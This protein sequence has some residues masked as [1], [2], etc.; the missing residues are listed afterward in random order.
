MLGVPFVPVIDGVSLPE[1]PETAAA[2]GS[3]TQVPVMIGCT[4]GEYVT[5]ATAQPEMDFVTVVQLLH[6]RVRP[7]GLSGEE[8]VRRYRQALPDHTPRGIWRA[9]AGDLVFQNPT[10]RFSRAHAEY[11]P[12]YKYL[13]GA[14]EPDEMG[15]PHGAEVGEVW[16]RDGMDLN[17]LPMRQAIADRNFAKVVHNVWVSFILDN[18][19]RTPVG[20]WPVY[21]T[22]QP[23]VLRLDRG[24]IGIELDPFDGRTA[25]WQ[26]SSFHAVGGQS[27]G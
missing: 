1:H 26:D 11:Q 17:H 25:L 16:Y 18:E 20:A 15:A 24:R 19:P 9:V 12:V 22:S 14:I 6:E 27:H 13:Y 3:A 7:L 21:S 10:T 23:K 2:Q 8:I 5:H 4:T